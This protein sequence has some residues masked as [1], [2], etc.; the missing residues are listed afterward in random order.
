MCQEEVS[1]VPWGMVPFWG[2]SV[3]VCY[4]KIRYSSS[5]H[6]KRGYNAV[7]VHFQI[8]PAYLGDPFT[9]WAQVFYFLST[10]WMEVPR[11]HSGNI[12][13]KETMQVEIVSKQIEPLLYA[14]CVGQQPC[15]NPFFYILVLLDDRLLPHMYKF[16]NKQIRHGKLRLHI[17]LMSPSVCSLTRPHSKPESVSQSKKICFQSS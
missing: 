10:C 16:M 2:L 13:G 5:S 8:I 15:S 12:K 11:A 6:L 9:N 17:L 1:W 7:M 4:W 14:T 3:S